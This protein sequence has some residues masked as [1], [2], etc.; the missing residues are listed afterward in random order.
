MRYIWGASGSGLSEH[1]W[2]TA[3][4]SGAAWVGNDAAAHITL[5]RPTV[6]EELAFGMEQQGVPR[7]VMESRIADAVDLWG[8]GEIIDRDPSRLSTGQTRRV[9]VAAALLRD[10]GALVLDCPTDGLDAAAVDTLAETLGRFSA[11][12]GDVTVYDRVDT[13]LTALADEQLRLDAGTLTPAPAPG[14][15]LPD[16]AEM[17]PAAP[18]DPV[19]DCACTVTNGSFTLDASLVARAGQVTH[20]AG[21]NG[22]GKT[23][24]MLAVLGLLPHTGRLVA[25]TAGWAPTGMDAAFSKR[26]VFR[27]LMVGADSA[28]ARAA[29]EWVGLEQW[30]DIHPLDVPSSARR[31]VAVAA[32]LVRGPELL[33]VDEPTV[34]L[35][36]PGHSWL[37]RVLRGYAA[38]EYHR[39]LGVGEKRPAVLWSCHNASFAQVVSDASVRL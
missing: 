29:L 27:E 15:E 38:G 36:A 25:P 21:P 20:L 6:R 23:T 35:D 33:L 34:G 10:P 11:E 7:E 3:E 30:T 32:A 1:A 22:S 8:L 13:P 16:P 19:L 2:A 4:A 14:P 28:H 31:M 5:L 9:A 37:A 39:V 24:L 17:A 12:V 26:S 18:G